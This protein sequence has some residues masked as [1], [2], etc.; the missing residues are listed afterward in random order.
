MPKEIKRELSLPCRIEILRRASGGKRER[1]VSGAKGE[2]L[3]TIELNAYDW[4]I[5]HSIPCSPI[6]GINRTLF[7]FQYLFKVLVILWVNMYS[8]VCRCEKTT[9][10][11]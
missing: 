2:Y 6:R 4:K 1:D 8:S 7:V 11:L 5:V 9:S 10:A 3:G